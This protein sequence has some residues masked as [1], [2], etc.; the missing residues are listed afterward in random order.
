MANL[1]DTPYF[2]DQDIG[3]GSL[4]SAPRIEKA[5]NLLQDNRGI[6]DALTQ[7]LTFLPASSRAYLRNISGSTT[8]I[9]EDFFSS[10]QL[11][12]AKRRTA[13]AMAEHS[14]DPNTWNAL[15][16]EIPYTGESPLAFRSTF[17][18]PKVD[19]DMTLGTSVYVENP[20]GTISVIDKHD[21]DSMAGAT[22]KGFYSEKGD[23]IYGKA[24]SWDLEQGLTPKVV[25]PSEPREIEW[26]NER[27]EFHDPKIISDYVND[28]FNPVNKEKIASM[29]GPADQLDYWHPAMGWD[30][31]YFTNKYEVSES[32]EDY[33]ARALK[34]R[35]EG[36]IGLSKLFRIIGGTYG[37]SGM[38]QG[39]EYYKTRG[40]PVRN[41][42]F[43]PV[44]INL[45]K[46]SHLDKLK[47]N[48]KFARYIAETET[49]PTKIREEARKLLPKKVAARHAPSE[50][51]EPDRGG[52]RGSM[53]TGTAG[54][55]P[56]GRADGGLA[57]MFQRRQ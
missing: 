45:G 16:K 6:V 56:W 2:E 38:T 17:T 41:P 39:H 40:I 30:K 27:T 15:N 52:Q 19:L 20:D 23:K 47:A 21:F 48:K 32:D 54:R 5:V 57:T 13:S 1:Y 18:D 12:E 29:T 7:N 51:R 37:H 33:I 31:E 24:S 25:P 8:P 43:L 26:L 10:N 4:I 11:S 28:P 9:T 34:A 46:I 44:N 3:I 53:P 55:N 35:K 50:Y 49:I 42:S 36:D 22:G 14:M